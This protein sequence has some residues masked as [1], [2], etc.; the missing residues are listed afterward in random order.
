MDLD[1]TQA[2]Y[3]VAL[4]RVMSDLMGTTDLR[5][6]VAV[7]FT[8]PSELPYLYRSEDGGSH[9]ASLQW[10]A[11]EECATMRLADLVQDDALD[12]LWGPAWPT[13]PGHDHPPQATIHDGRATWVCPRSG[14][15][16]AIIGNLVS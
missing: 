2:T 1:R 6:Q 5:P 9:G 4:G 13:C 10:D 14:H 8:D 16:L 11:D 15:A 12:D 3:D 7:D